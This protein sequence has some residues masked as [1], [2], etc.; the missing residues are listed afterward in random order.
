LAA[1]LAVVVPSFA[2]PSGSGPV[3]NDRKLQK[4]TEAAEQRDEMSRAAVEYEAMRIAPGTS[5]DPAAFATARAAAVS[6]PTVGGAWSELTTKRYDSDDPN[7]R[8]PVWSNSGG[9][10]GLVSGR[11][12][13][14][15][16]DP[17]NART[18]YAGAADGGVWKSTDRGAH[19]TPV[20]DGQ[21]TQTV[22]ADGSRLYAV[23]E[24]TFL[25]NKPTCR[26]RTRS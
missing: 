4:D 15:A 21:S 22:S 6:L 18:V 14:V 19:W 7:Y 2:S 16:V 26:P 1:A 5:L 20:F 9:G 8:D 11:M 25:Y 3:T 12:T 24:D 17:R 13:A 10:A 23:V